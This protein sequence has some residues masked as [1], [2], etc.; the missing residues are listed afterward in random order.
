MPISRPCRVALL[1]SLLLAAASSAQP[2]TGS[3]PSEIDGKNI[4]QWVS[5]L[6][7]NDPSVR[8][9]AIRAVV[10]FGPPDASTVTA[11]I[12]RLLDRDGAPRARAI[13]ALAYLDLSRQDV[14]RVVEALGKRV[15]VEHEPQSAV[16]YAAAL[17]LAR[18]GEEARP[19]IKDLIKA[20][21]DQATFDIRRVACAALAM[22]GHNKDGGSD[23]RAARALI[24]ALKDPAFGVRME[25][26]VGLGYMGKLSD[27]AV[28]ALAIKDLQIL[29]KDRDLVTAIWATVS[30]MALDKTSDAQIALIAKQLKS[31]DA[32]VRS[33]AARALGS[34]AG[35]A[36]AHVPDLCEALRDKEP[37]T[38]AVA[39]WALARMGTD[40]QSAVPLLKQL[41]DAKEGNE[42]VKYA[43]QQAID[44]I[45]K[46]DPMK[47]SP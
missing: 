44:T 35:K 42:G 6:K 41:V 10:A 16:R 8:E 36:K 11:L 43:A 19:A 20:T 39:C 33:H 28:Q 17:A 9:E 5:E 23:P 32:R 18:F 38:V 15:N 24:A 4:S 7:N 30:L 27:P 21:E 26:I 12:D 3:P 37:G 31:Q 34:L 13:Q 47:K 40:A 29:T 22:A 1:A 25:A 2:R 45:T 14:P 46:T